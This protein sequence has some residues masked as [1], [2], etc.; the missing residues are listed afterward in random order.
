MDTPSTS[1]S[2]KRHSHTQADL[3]NSRLLESRQ[4]GY[5]SGTKLNCPHQF[6]TTR[7]FGSCLEE[8]FKHAHY[9]LSTLSAVEDSYNFL[10]QTGGNSRSK[11]DMGEERAYKEES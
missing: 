3:Q 6:V 9:L 11:E 1:R 5:I 7:T 4:A 10:P 2:A 8:I